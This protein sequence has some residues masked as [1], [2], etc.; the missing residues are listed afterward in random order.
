MKKIHLLVCLFFLFTANIFAQ[1]QSRDVIWLKSGSVI[2]GQII[3]QVINEYVLIDIGTGTATKIPIESI[4]KITKEIVG[5]NN[6]AQ[7]GFHVDKFERTP[8]KPKVYIDKQTRIVASFGIGLGVYG[9]ATSQ[10]NDAYGPEMVSE[11]SIG[12]YHK[13]FMLSGLSSFVYGEPMYALSLGL[14]GRYFFSEAKR[15]KSYVFG[16]VGYTMS[17]ISEQDLSDYH[18]RLTVDQVHGGKQLAVGFGVLTKQTETNKFGFYWQLGYHHHTLKVTGNYRTGG[19][20]W[21]PIGPITWE[22]VEKAPM[23]YNRL[24]IVGGFY[25]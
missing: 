4:Q 20:W 25:F 23:I 22:R 18:W 16:Q 3:E 15:T 13:K 1:N 17:V 19:D 6:D 10:V 21:D 5:S 9:D 7:T 11:V 14:D 8:I 24:R 12:Y 2:K